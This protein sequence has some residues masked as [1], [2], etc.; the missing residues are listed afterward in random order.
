MYAVDVVAL[1]TMR[2]R[3]AT[4]GLLCDLRGTECEDEE[5]KAASRNMQSAHLAT[6]HMEFRPI[7]QPEPSDSMMIG[8]HGLLPFIT[9]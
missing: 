4:T 6:G 9:I 5:S 8:V 1:G 7:F 2:S 3:C